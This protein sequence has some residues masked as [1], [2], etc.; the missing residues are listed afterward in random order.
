MTLL[1]GT[2]G[3]WAVALV[4]STGPAKPERAAELK[5]Q[6]EKLATEARTL[7]NAS[8]CAKVEECE[9]AGFGHKS[10]GGP[11]EYIAYCAKTTDVKA[12]QSKLA[13]L[14]KAGKTWQAETGEM[15]NCSLTRRPPPRFV[16]GVCRTR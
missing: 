1:A 7:A 4:L 15:S 12:L 8:G 2:M 3:A 14:E 10:C 9:V 16:D 6:A 13:E 5:Q 11:R